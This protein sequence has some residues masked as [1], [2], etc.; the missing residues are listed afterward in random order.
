MGKKNQEDE[1]ESRRV[2]GRG[3]K[4][5]N[6]FNMAIMV[7]MMIVCLYPFWYVVCASF[8]EASLLLGHTGGLL[9]P[10]GF[11]TAA[12]ERVFANSRIWIGYANTLFYV[13]VGTTLNIILTVL[14]AFFLS[15][16][17]L[18]GK[19]AITL[20]IMF[21]MYF[22]G[23][24]IPAFLNIQD[25]GL[26]KS[27]G[28]SILS[29]AISTYNMMIMRSA[30][31]SID[32]SLEESALLDGA[33]YTTILFRILLPLTKATV[34]VLV[35]YYGVGN[36]NS[37]FSAMLYLSAADKEPLQ[38]VIRSI[39][40]QSQMSDMGDET[41]LLTEVIKYAT[42]VV[43]TVPILVIYPF[44]QKYFTKGTMVG[45]VKG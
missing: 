41:E 16:E 34:A 14:G 30:I 12:Y 45:S 4:I 11:S 7:F 39:L 24:M 31:A 9:T 36:W 38:L 35:I 27:R 28:A 10:L 8:S 1:N 3:E 5:F 19:K 2:I 20:L 32:K 25:L 17:N 40:I 37:W 21:T 43:A 6:I 26:Y 23:G 44:M 42:I 15:R 33:N 13:V 22:S 18:P 29:G